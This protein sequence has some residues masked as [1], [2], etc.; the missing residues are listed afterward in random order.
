VVSKGEADKWT[1]QAVREAKDEIDIDCSPYKRIGIAWR[2]CSRITSHIRYI[3]HPCQTSGFGGT[4]P[5][6]LPLIP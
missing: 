5:S 4:N 2:C 3:P 6:K 1:E